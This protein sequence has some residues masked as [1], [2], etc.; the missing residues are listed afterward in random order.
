[1]IEIYLDCA[2]LVSVSSH[3]TDERVSG[4]TTNPTLMRQAGVANYRQFAETMLGYASDRH[5]SFEVLNDDAITMQKEAQ[6][7][8]SL[9]SNVYVK[10]PV[11]DADGKCNSELIKRLLRSGIS[12]NITAVHRLQDA[13]QIAAVCDT[14]SRAVLSVFAGRIA[15][16]GRDPTSHVSA[17]K[18]VVATLPNVKLLWASS[19]E[20]LNVVQAEACGCDVITLTPSLLSKL[21]G[22]GRSL[23][24]VTVETVR[25]FAA[26]SKGIAPIV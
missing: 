22:L 23:D 25:M 8:A 6:E 11:V 10:V 3:A 1:M 9:G 2:D 4:F 20:I 18:Q 15:D 17:I 21:S 16:T 13:E 26:A 19:R 12:V 5:V 24:E 7:L 14:E